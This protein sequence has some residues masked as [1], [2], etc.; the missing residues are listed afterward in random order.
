MGILPSKEF[1]QG[2]KNNTGKN[3]LAQG[4]LR[5]NTGNFILAGMWPPCE[6]F[7]QQNENKQECIPVGCVPSASVAI[8]GCR[9]GGASAQGVC[10]RGCLPW[11][12]PG[13]ASALGVSRWVCVGGGGVH[14]CVCPGGCLPRWEC[15]VN[16]N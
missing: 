13:G 8:S 6:G 1:Y 3:Y 5:E 10:Q 2:Y 4:K 7:D 11:G 16:R 15:Q 12:C 9:E 14:G